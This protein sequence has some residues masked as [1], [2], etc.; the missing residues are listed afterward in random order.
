MPTYVVTDPNSGRKVKLTGDS[1]PTDA[2]LD[3]IF[4]SIP[5]PEEKGLLGKA[6]DVAL[7]G[8][9]A[10]NRGATNLADFAASP[11]NAALELSGSDARIPSLTQAASA[12][13]TGNFMQDGITK[14]IV[15]KGGEAIPASLAVGGMLRAAAAPL[16]GQAGSASALPA[17]TAAS[18]GTGAGALRQLGSSTIAQDIGF[19][20]LSGGGSAVGQEVGGDAGGMIGAVAAPA[21]VALIPQAAKSALQGIFGNKSTG[22]AAKIIDDFASIGEVPTA[23][24]ASG[25]PALQQ[26]ETVSSSVM[27]GGSLR[28]KSESIAANMQKRL[29]TIADDLS[30]KEGAEI[31]GL[32]IKKGIQGKGG[33]LDRFRST[34]SVLWNK[35][36]SMID[37]ASPVKLD[38]TKTMLDQIVRGDKVGEILDNPK[39]VQLKQIVDGAD[40]LDYSTLKS[41]RSS[42][43]QK[44]GNNELVSDIPRAELKRVYGALTQDIK[45]AAQGAGD[46]ALKAFERANR[47]TR[48]GHDRIDDYLERISTKVE[49]EKIF[50]AVARGGEGTQT[51]NAVKRSL[52]PEE[53][54]VVASNVVRRMGR[55]SSGNQTAEGD[56]FSVDK[57]VTDWDKLGSAK[58]A[59]FSGSEKLDSYGDDLAKI[60]R[61]ASTVKQ[62]ARQ[63]S[64][65]SGTAQAASRIAAGT[66]LAT[67]VLS[68][69]PTILGLTAGSIAMNTAGARLMANPG[70]VKWLAQSAKIPAKNS[71][72]A[73]GALSGVAN[74]S[75][76]DDAAIIQQ[77]VEELESD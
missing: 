36:D 51:I 27:G 49:P 4:A 18:E 35:A 57:F 63:G 72:A 1:P 23:G 71:A 31:A 53:W 52:K 62:A 10:V 47:Y 41:L 42:I 74:Q 5:A 56:A 75:S 55:A 66:G 67:G 37:P 73:I 61:V 69:S 48:T 25:K 13:T 19:G 68:A 14:E 38:N 77:L 21:A 17:L 28:T 64:N 30:T 45:V 7:E 70:F 60:A 6:G 2:D 44:I 16:V 15:R 34:S 24:M 33:F 11:V 8:M 12:G 59:L 29:A 39:L 43:G 20:A 58:K 9:A 22:Q 3:E 54:E 65:Y 76:A 32:E 40:N 26:A 46:D 50:Q